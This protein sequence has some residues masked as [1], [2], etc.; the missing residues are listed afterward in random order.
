MSMKHYIITGP[1]LTVKQY[2]IAGK[3][4]D[5]LYYE[6]SDCTAHVIFPEFNWGAAQTREI[7]DEHLEHR[8]QI[9]LATRYEAGVSHM[10]NNEASRL[11]GLVHG[12]VVTLLF[13]NKDS[14]E[15]TTHLLDVN[16]VLGNKWPMGI[17][18]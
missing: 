17:L 8:K 3:L 5:S 15:P 13:H 18:W 11:F 6:L 7:L 4:I 14:T 16:G 1:E 12:S 2:Q 10:L 9:I